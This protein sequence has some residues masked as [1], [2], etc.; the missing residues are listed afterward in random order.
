MTWRL[1]SLA[2]ICAALLLAGPVGSAQACDAEAQH[3]F[4]VVPGC[5]DQQISGPPTAGDMAPAFHQAGGH[6]YSVTVQANVNAPAET[7]PV[8]GTHWPPEPLRDMVIRLPRGI[9]ANTVNVVACTMD[10]LSYTEPGGGLTGSLEDAPLCPPASQVGTASLNLATFGEETLALAGVPLYYM[11]S[12]AGTIARFGFTVLG[13]VVLADADL[14]AHQEVVLRI[15]RINQGIAFLGAGVTLWGAP[16]DPAHTEERACPG[17]PSPALAE[18]PTTCSAGAPIQAFL[19]L[20]TSCGA[21]PETIMEVDSWTHPGDYRTLSV[22]NHNPPGIL[23]DPTEFAGYPVE[24]PGFDAA[25]W[26]PPQG[27]TGCDQ[28]PFEPTVTVEPTSLAAGVPTGLDLGLSLPQRGFTQPDQ[29]SEADLA[30]IGVALP[31][32]LALNPSV[33]NG[34][35]TCSAAQAAIESSQPSMCPDSA[36]LGTVE[37]TSPALPQPLLGSIELAP[38]G[39][40]ASGLELPVYLIAEG[41][42]ISLKLT[43]RIVLD[44]STGQLT[45]RLSDAPQ[46]PIGKLLLHF[47]GGQRAPFVNPRACGRYESRA[48]LTPWSGAGAVEADSSFELTSGPGGSPCPVTGA[49]RP[50]APGF[51]AGVA[52]PTADGTGPFTLWLSRADG[53]QEITDLDLTLPAGLSASLQGTGVCPDAALAGAASADRP[54]S[55]E[56]ATPSCPAES[57]VGQVELRLGVGEEPFPLSTGKVYLA[58]PYQ[59]GRFSLAAVIP[60]VA[61]PID[62][63]STVVRLAVRV[64]PTDGHLSISGRLPTSQRGVGLHLQSLALTL[65]REGFVVNPTTCG[66]TSVGGV[67]DGSEGGVARA[68]SRFQ[69]VDCAALPFAPR[70]GLSFRGGPKAAKR[71]AHPG[72][73]ATVR[74][75]R[76]ESRI[77][78][79][80][81]TLPASEQL[82]PAHIRNVCGPSQLASGQCPAG[83]RIGAIEAATPL[84]GG[85]LAGS[86]YLVSAAHDRF[87][88][89][90]ARLS[91]EIEIDLRGAIRFRKGRV[92]LLFPSLP[93][94]PISVLQLRMVGGRRGLLVNNRSLCSASTRV[95]ARLV[96]QGGQRATIH[97][98]TAK[99]CR[100]RPARN[101]RADESSGGHGLTERRVPIGTR[102]AV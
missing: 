51:V 87:P 15:K 44:E 9:V 41:A 52:N 53:E 31:A 33:A 98:P 29:I 102:T 37:V 6:P 21:A 24:Y 20:P 3:S 67:I 42:G 79:A 66:P 1:G 82:D 96:G 100:R 75:Q 49:S 72:L 55:A 58:G 73:L 47:F 85:R 5:F 34:L 40:V 78:R 95:R 10:Q 77:K 56:L 23:G 101:P 84:L 11:G 2:A 8:N 68:S 88:Q 71:R 94:L 92:T 32:G 90:A 39:S 16:A 99:S 59:G 60:A 46:L 62:L 65:D 63:G 19:R 69:M 36:K 48:R 17:Q 54:G 76:G 4:G 22:T 74:A 30:D 81:I 89:V 43:A 14:G 83:S 28:V 13:V 7:D 18:N 91:G 25:K 38:G 61:G 26:G 70:L 97:A 45:A 50:F 12:P 93:D 80:A 35:A 86:L 64:D 57:Q 27:F